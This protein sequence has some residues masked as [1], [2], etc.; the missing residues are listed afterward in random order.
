MF[1]CLIWDNRGHRRFLDSK[2]KEIE[3]AKSRF[4]FKLTI[5]R[6]IRIH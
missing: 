5:W 6:S 3:E 2:T 1:F 4:K